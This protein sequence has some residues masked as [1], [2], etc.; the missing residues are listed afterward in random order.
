[1]ND[2]NLNTTNQTLNTEVTPEVKPVNLANTAKIE[3]APIQNGVVQSNKV[4]N[5]DV[6]K[7]TE[8]KKKVNLPLIIL[9]VIVLAFVIGLIVYKINNKD[10]NAS[11]AS[12][13]GN[14]LVYTKKTYNNKLNICLKKNKVYRVVAFS[15]NDR[16]STT[17]YINNNNYSSTDSRNTSS[18]DSP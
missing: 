10:T 6:V 18:S 1:M 14:N 11:V 15:L 12:V 16:I 7:N 3:M 13:E 17:I 2:N 8:S 5:D 4:F 9:L